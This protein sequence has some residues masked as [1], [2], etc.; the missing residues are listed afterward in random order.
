MPNGTP[1]RLRGPLF[2]IA[3]AAGLSACAGLPTEGE[4]AAENTLEALKHASSV[5]DPAVATALARMRA[6]PTAHILSINEL[7]YAGAEEDVVMAVV[8][9]QGADLISEPKG[10]RSQYPPPY[11]SGY[12][13]PFVF[14]NAFQT[15]VSTSRPALA[16]KIAVHVAKQKGDYVEGLPLG[17]IPSV[18]ALATALH[19]PDDGVESGRHFYNSSY[20]PQTETVNRT[21]APNAYVS[22]AGRGLMFR[23][24]AAM[25]V[26]NS[27]D[28]HRRHDYA[29]ADIQGPSTYTGRVP[30]GLYADDF[31]KYISG[32]Q[33]ET[34][35]FI[36]RNFG[37][38]PNEAL[39]YCVPTTVEFD[40]QCMKMTPMQL[41]ARTTSMANGWLANN[42]TWRIPGK[43]N[44]YVAAGGD[45]Q[46]TDSFGNTALAY[47][48]NGGRFP[49][50][51]S[52]GFDLD[53]GQVF[54]GAAV[55]AGAG[56]LASEGGG[57]QAIR[58]LGAGAAD[59][60]N[61][62]TSNMTGL[63]NQVM[64]ENA[65]AANAR[66]GG[67]GGGLA[68]GGNAAARP[69]ATTQNYSFTC[70]MTPGKTKSIP[71]SAASSQCR[72]AMQTYARVSSC[73]MIDEME[74]AQQ[75]YYS[76]CASEIY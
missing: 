70:P 72:S 56:Y 41:A 44:A 11:V 69:V 52:S 33:A 62:T 8:E 13:T 25:T 48:Q 53:I 27:L 22:P 64:R 49:Q 14:A 16:E 45:P 65:V 50:S 23:H 20:Y 17:A 42:W 59:L 29:L 7:I 54:A 35:A 43:Y 15:A 32:R 37:G 66:A 5:N 68:S 36:Q 38:D 26:G 57:E 9:V 4:I 73:N 71:I 18:V 46:T 34:V 63:N 30:V 76:Q 74:A 55:L 19:E 24:A 47:A 39:P 75:A 3:L 61:G 31:A 60:A 10:D 12:R 40:L 2:G 67:S 21:V 51:E 58:F 28:F 1:K 6:D